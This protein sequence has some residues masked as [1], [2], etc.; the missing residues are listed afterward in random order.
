[1]KKTNKLM[2]G[3]LA[4]AGLI[5]ITTTMAACESPGNSVAK[6]PKP[7]DSTCK[8]WDWEEDLGVWECDD[9]KSSYHGGYY[10]GGTY[11]SNSSALKSSS[12]YQ[13]YSK[14]SSFAGKSTSIS[15]GKSGVGS[16]SKGGST[17]S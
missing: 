7:K 13:S 6:P 8:N 11:Y 2:K 1:M 14:S 16:G 9:K 17:G 5:T 4:T 15:S 10:Y 3:V 12:G